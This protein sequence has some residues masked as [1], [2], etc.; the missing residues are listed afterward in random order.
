M[1]GKSASA[2]KAAKNESIRRGYAKEYQSTNWIKKGQPKLQA[3]N[4]KSKLSED[5]KF[6]KALLEELEEQYKKQKSRRDLLE[7]RTVKKRA[8]AAE[9]RL[10]GPQLASDDTYKRK[11]VQLRISSALFE[12]LFYFMIV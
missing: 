12:K 9:R 11:Q 2:G 7:A 3:L 6:L 1:S 10:V 8:T 4:Q 5:E